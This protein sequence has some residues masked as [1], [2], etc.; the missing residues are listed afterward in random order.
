MQRAIITGAS[1]GIGA[2]V[3]REMS[4]R[5]Y[6]LALIARRAELLDQLVRELPNS[7]A[8]PCDVTD[9][10]AVH[11]A[12]KRAGQ[13]DVAIANAGVGMMGWAAK[14][15]ADAEMMMRVNYFGML[16]LF[17]AV[18]P[19]MIERRSGHFAGIASLAGL[20]GL[21]TASGYSASK[22]AIQAFLDSA[23]AELARFGIRV[24]T[25]NPGFIATAMTDKFTFKPPLMMHVDKAAKIIVNGIER[26]GR[27]VEFPWPTSIAVRLSRMLPAWMVDRVMSGYGRR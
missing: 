22:A 11:E 23:R 2:A 13:C 20:R 24:T 19:S 27:I 10:A 6:A 1:S 25:V 7:I 16:Y 9:S 14:S 18:I 12:V 17:D 4:R 5:G 8:L 26:G 15:V 21:P 3:A